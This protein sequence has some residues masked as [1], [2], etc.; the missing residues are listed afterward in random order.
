MNKKKAMTG[1]WQCL[2][3]LRSLVRAVSHPID[4]KS[5]DQ[6]TEPND[7]TMSDAFIESGKSYLLFRRSQ[8]NSPIYR[9]CLSVSG[10]LAFT[11]TEVRFERWVYYFDLQDLLAKSTCPQLLPPS[12]PILL[13]TLANSLAN[14]VTLDAHISQN[15]YLDI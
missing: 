5:T 13:S 2:M 11:S 4:Y 15:T 9:S 7:T 1:S 10:R 14:M 8:C 6:Y 3:F 12:Q